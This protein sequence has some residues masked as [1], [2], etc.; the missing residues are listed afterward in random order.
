MTMMLNLEEIEAR[1]NAATPGPWR[2]HATFG[3]VTASNGPD[4][5]GDAEHYGAQL[6]AESCT[7]IDKAFIAH[8]REDVPVLCK[9]IRRLRAAI[10]EAHRALTASLVNGPH[11]INV[12]DA[13]LGK[14]PAGNPRKTT[15]TKEVTHGAPVVMPEP[16]ATVGSGCAESNTCKAAGR[17][18]TPPITPRAPAIS[19]DLLGRLSALAD[20]VRDHLPVRLRTD[21]GTTTLIDCSGI[22]VAD[23]LSAGRRR[24]H[25][26]AFDRYLRDAFNLTPALVEEI[27]RRRGLA[28]QPQRGTAIAC[29]PAAGGRRCATH[30]AL[31]LAGDGACEEGRS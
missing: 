23:L 29:V 27:R 1:A 5:R 14:S 15:Q 24:G 30:N 11:A 10:E 17:A 16:G 18:G 9:E 25:Y 2:A 7:K 31:P 3:C 20:G 22:A 28:D 21:G 12:L 13:A 19:D 8:V 4:P 26:L 6:I